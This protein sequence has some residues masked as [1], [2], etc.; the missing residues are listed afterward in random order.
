MNAHNQPDYLHTLILI[1]DRG[2]K[3]NS[4]KFAPLRALGDAGEFNVETD[5]IRLEWLANRFLT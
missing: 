5:T 2:L 4:Y 1:L 3:S